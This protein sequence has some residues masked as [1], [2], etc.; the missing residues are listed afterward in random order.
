M[1]AGAVGDYAAKRGRSAVEIREWGIKREPCAGR[2]VDAHGRELFGGQRG[3][4][5]KEE[6]IRD[7][8]DEGAEAQSGESWRGPPLRV[9]FRFAWNRIVGP[10]PRAATM[11]I[12]SSIGIW[13]T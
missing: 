7:Q 4:G 5:R 12:A 8:D 10:V 11:R 6:K 1:T 13:K 9:A 3:R 2:R